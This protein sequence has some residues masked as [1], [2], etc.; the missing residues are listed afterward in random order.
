EEKPHCGERQSW[1][2]GTYRDASSIRR[3]SSSLDS[4]SPVLVVTRPSTTCLPGGTNRNGAKP[5][6]RC[7]SYSR[8]NPS[9]A[10]SENSDS[11]TKSY[12]PSAAQEERKLPRHRWVVTRSSGG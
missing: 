12:P 11:A 10:S 2:S 8:K 9:T 5:P 4:S 3:L 6:A 1:S 7:V